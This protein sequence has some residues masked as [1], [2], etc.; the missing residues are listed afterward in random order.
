MAVIDVK[1]L[2]SIDRV[3]VGASL[4]ALI[5]MF[6]PWYGYSSTFG[7]ASVS[8]FG[9]GYGWFGALLVIAAGVYLGLIRSGSSVPKTSMGPG[10]IVL[11]ASAIGTALVVIRW[12]SLPSGSGTSGAGGAYSYS[13]GPRV[14]LIITLIAALVQVV[15]S[16]RLFKRSGEAL[17][18]AK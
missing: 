15:C 8:G 11:G 10:V 4:V 18:W 9:S 7:G 17:P 12:I 14:G 6:L 13:Y 5:A 16:F 3:V 2:S 1:R